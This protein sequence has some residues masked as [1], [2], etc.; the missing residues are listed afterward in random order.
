VVF[1]ASNRTEEGPA[2]RPPVHHL[3]V[4]RLPPEPSANEPLKLV[5]DIV[6]PWY[7]SMTIARTPD[8]RWLASGG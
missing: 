6:E 1:R 4:F 3:Y 2:V 5:A 7:P 8:G